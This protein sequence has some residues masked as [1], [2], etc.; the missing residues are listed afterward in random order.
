MYLC[1]K[2]HGSEKPNEHLQTCILKS[3]H[4]VISAC[5]LCSSPSWNSNKLP[6]AGKSQELPTIGRNSIADFHLSEPF[7]YLV[8]DEMLC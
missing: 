6:P 5:T 8:L 3:M 4:H 2:S 1:S 7:P